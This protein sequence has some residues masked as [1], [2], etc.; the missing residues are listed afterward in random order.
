MARVRRSTAVPADLADERVAAWVS[1]EEANMI[2]NELAAVAD[3]DRAFADWIH[4]R[5]AQLGAH[6]P[7]W[8]YNWY[9][10]RLGV[11]P[12]DPDDLAVRLIDDLADSRRITAIDATGV[13]VPQADRRDCRRCVGLLLGDGPLCF[14]HA[15]EREADAR[16]LLG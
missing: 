15:A 5:A 16:E 10:A 1:A 14:R 9:R 3:D 7:Q 13:D 6:G 11:L 12:D 8:T 2:R 4:D